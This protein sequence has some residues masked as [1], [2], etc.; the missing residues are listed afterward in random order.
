MK[1]LKEII[2]LTMLISFMVLC[3]ISIYG[4]IVMRKNDWSFDWY[5]P[6]SIVA[7][8]F[9]CS[10]VTSFLLYDDGSGKAVPAIISHLKIA[11]HFILLYGVIMGAGH[12]FYWYKD[13]QGFILTSVIYVVI[14][15]GAWIGSGIMF[16]RDEKMISQALENIRDRD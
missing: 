7:S 3:Y 16:R 5:I 15:V 11:A 13:M 6:G 12:L 8:G 1:R 10:L 4:L 14:Y 9:L 2:Q